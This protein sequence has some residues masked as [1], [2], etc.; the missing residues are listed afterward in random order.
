MQQTR[1]YILEIL[2][3]RGEATVDEMVSELKTRIQHNITAVTVRHHLD[4]L[5]SDSLVT[6]P[7]V[8]RSGAPGRPQYVYALTDKALE[9]FPNNYQNLM[10]TLLTQMKSALPESQ[11]VTIFEGV[12][13]QMVAGAHLPHLS[14]N[15]VSMDEKLN[16]VV[17][18]LN[19]NGYNVNWEASPEGY[20]LRNHNCP[21]HKVSDNHGELC[22]MDF[23]LIAGL[24]GIAPR[25][26]TLLSQDEEGCTFLIPASQ[27]TA[28]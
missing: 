6:A 8:R 9:V 26:M 19:E 17:N 14:S 22:N 20:I 11:I 4:I 1:R 23:R 5:R 13:D 12:A 27:Q 7:T 10:S 16:Y 24:I 15:H 18:Y 28:A 25:A 2:R 21:Y 3:E